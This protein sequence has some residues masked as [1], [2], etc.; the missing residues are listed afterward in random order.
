MLAHRTGGP[1]YPVRMGVPT[2]VKTGAAV[3]ATALVGSRAAQPDSH[4]YRRL[5]KPAWQPPP[6]AFP[7]VWT[8]L[9]GLLAYAGARAVDATPP[10]RRR[11]YLRAYAAN[12]ALNAGWTA[13]FFR[14]RR[15]GAALA[16]I[17]ALNAS[18]VDLLRRTSAADLVAGAALAPYAA[19]T[20]F[21]TAV[22]AE[23]VRRNR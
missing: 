21:A 13:V 8:V 11:A 14:A 23:I 20:A 9:Y 7:I 10:D 4:W 18:T 3:A 17:V 16:E 2:W 12:L 19:W 15:P 1:G 22:N 5:D 6:Q